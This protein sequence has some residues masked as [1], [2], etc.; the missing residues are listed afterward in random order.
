MTLSVTTA[1][2]YLARYVTEYR[3]EYTR[4]TTLPPEG[5][6]YPSLVVSPYLY[7][8]ELLCLLSPD[9]AI[10]VDQSR[11]PEYQWWI[12][13]GPAFMTDFPETR[14]PTEIVELLKAQGRWGKPI[15]I[16]RIVAQQGVPEELWQGQFGDI[17]E[18]TTTTVDSI[19]ITVRS[20][21]WS[22]VEMLQRLT[23]GA[24]GYILDIHLRGYESDFWLPHIIRHTGF[25]TADRRYRRFFNYLEIL[26]HVDKAAWDTRTI[27]T[28]VQV[29]VRRDFGWAFSRSEQDAGYISFGPAQNW[30][31]PFYDRLSRLGD[32][33]NQFVILLNECEEDDERIFHEF[34]RAHSILLDVYGDAVS[35]PRFVYPEDESPLGKAYVEP[36]FI[37]KYP[38]GNY[39]LVELEKPA[40]LMATKHG[41]PRAEVNQAAF[42]IAEWRA[43]IANHYDQLKTDFPGLAVNHTAMIVISRTTQ[44]S[45]GEGRNIRKY[46]EL[47]QSQFPTVDILTYDE[48]LER[49]RGAYTR[50]AGLGIPTQ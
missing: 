44:R 45:Y 27:L 11:E 36:D 38:D 16:Y 25:C 22:R 5:S 2:A 48:L 1:A 17:I 29:D 46:K 13:G 35:K 26:P 50:L 37:I 47:L 42:Q 31:Q 40:K 6:G 23:F 8:E 19:R 41:Q 10:I 28:R 12:A 24:L 3:R 43:F 15:G 20:Y 18:D 7:S 39:K 32:T 49:A 21:R 33:I 9:G 4:L 30:I 14:T 34:L